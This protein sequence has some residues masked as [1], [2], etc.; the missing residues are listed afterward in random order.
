MLVG[1]AA[2]AAG[3]HDGLVIAAHL[4]GHFLLEG[5][6]VTGQIGPAEFVVESRCTD[7]P[8]D[9]DVE[10]RGNAIRL[11]VVRFPRLH[12]AGNAQI[13][14]SKA[15]QPGLGLGAA[16]SGALVTNL[17]ARAGSR[18]GERRNRGRMIVR[19]HLG[20]DM[21]ELL[22]P[23][24][25]AIWP[26]MKTIDRRALDDR[27]VVRI[28]ND[29]SLGM[30]LVRRANHAEQRVRLFGPIHRPRSIEDLV[31]AMF[32]VGLGEHH[33]LDIGRV[34]LE[35]REVI[36]QIIDLVRRQG[37]TE[38]YV[39]FDQRRTSLRHE[40]D[41]GQRLWR[42]VMEQGIGRI[43]RIEHRLGHAIMQLRRQ[44]TAIQLAFSHGME[45][46]AAL[47][48][49]NRPE[50]ALTRDF[51]GL[52]RPRRNGTEPRRHQQQLTFWRSRCNRRN[53]EQ[54]LQPRQFLIARHAFGFNEIPVFGG[55]PC[56]TGGHSA[57][58]IAQA[59]QPGKG[60]SV[61]AAQ[62]ENLGHGG[63]Y[64]ESVGMPEL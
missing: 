33:Q 29:G 21:R 58:A 3:D 64:W 26:R 36:D 1:N 47:D 41:A 24:I 42:N 8:L 22:A 34:A 40:I 20:Q 28:G 45:S 7:R 11:A 6:E 30:R 25:L 19:L 32:G 38:H 15:A 2:D 17:A 16:P 23:A 63:K 31:A 14:N 27:R 12:I 60:K 43:E 55:Q 35:P 49:A 44:Y 51:G 54:I 59:R 57:R 52:G 39:G 48:A 61:C 50:P 5:A 37:E 62:L 10:R 46:G 56:Q 4:A 9:H 13:G 53:T 18:T